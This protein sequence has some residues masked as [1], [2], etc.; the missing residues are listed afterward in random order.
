MNQIFDML[1]QQYL[2]DI[3]VLSQPW[4]YWYL[5]IP[6]LAYIS[7]MGIKWAILTLPFW[8]PFAII[9]NVWRDK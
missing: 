8:L 3:H 7:F 1:L 5:L 4:M 2:F 9:I 6:A